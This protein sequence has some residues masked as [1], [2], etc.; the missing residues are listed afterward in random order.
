MPRGAAPLSSISNPTSDFTSLPTELPELAIRWRAGQR[1]AASYAAIY[2]L[3]WQIFLHGESFAARKRKHDTRPNAREWLTVLRTCEGSLLREH[4]LGY[5]DGYQF[6]GV[7]ANVPAALGEWLRGAWKLELREDIPSPLDVLRAQACGT[8]PVTAI[9]SYPRSL[10]PVLGKAN[11]YAFFVHDIEHA[12]KFFHSPALYAGQRA[13]FERLL[14]AFERSI[15]ASYLED[16]VFVDKFHYLMSDMNTHPEHSRQYL[17][18]IMIEC[19]LRREAKRP[20]DPLSPGAE[21]ETEKVL[22]ELQPLVA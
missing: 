7:I 16:A 20:G 1:D 12:Y 18:A 8:R 3:V 19:H 21:R 14:D 17:R 13:F 22:S 2:F 4:L 11:A 9:A 5:L 10:Q 6:Y 15:F